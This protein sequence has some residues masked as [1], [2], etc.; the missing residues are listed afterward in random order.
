M[1]RGHHA[2]ARTAWRR[3]AVPRPAAIPRSTAMPI[4]DV[5]LLSGRRREDLQRLI[6]ALHETTVRV[7]DAPPESI[8]VLIRE[9]PAEHWGSGGIT[10]AEKRAAAQRHRPD[11][12]GR[13]NPVGE[14]GD[15]AR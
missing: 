8:K 13:P 15:G 6:H 2:A 12:A 1:G 7:L 10:M 11:P 5:S 4:I 9:I 3:F 14:S